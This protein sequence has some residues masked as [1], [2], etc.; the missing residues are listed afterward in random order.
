MLR[1]VSIQNFALI[2]HIEISFT[3]GFTVITGETGSGKSILLG[4]LGLVLGNRADTSVLLDKQRK[5]IVEVLFDISNNSQLQSWLEQLGLEPEADLYLR[6]EIAVTGKSRSFIND[7]PVNLSQLKDAAAMLVDLHQQFDTMELGEAYFQRNVI[8]ALAGCMQETS[9]YHKSFRHYSEQAAKLQLLQQQQ[10]QQ[11][12]E[13]DYRQFLLDELLAASFT[14]DELEKAE[15]ERTLLEHA[16]AVRSTLHEAT[17]LLKESETPVVQQL[18]VLLHKLQQY[19][20]ISSSLGEVCD[21]LGAVHIE[22]NDLASELEQQQDSIQADE[23]RKDYLTQRLELGY[24]LQKKHGV[25]STLQLLQ[26][27]ESLESEL[28]VLSNL[29]QEIAATEQLLRQQKQELSDKAALLYKKRLKEATPFAEKMNMLLKRVGM[30]NARMKVEVLPAPL[31]AYGAD[32]IRFLFNA[33]LPEHTTSTS[34]QME[35][36]GKVASGGELSRLM[37]CIQSLV[38]GKIELPSLI[39]DEIDTGISGEAARQVGLLL[40]ELSQ[41]HQVITITHLPQIAA[42]AFTHFYVYKEVQGAT[43]VTKV[44]QLKS[45]EQVEAIAHMLSGENITESTLLAAKE[46]VMNKQ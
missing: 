34:E 17:F 33:N 23:A 46:M 31:H 38:A 45:D 44:R 20:N 15:Q 8:D 39:F 16:E 2:D 29:E 35:P 19:R 9:S 37:L 24:K 12:R 14:A 13:Q 22:L 3:D 1:Q 32:T 5:C 36:I 25:Q 41:K 43:I 28:Q 30:P 18:K 27:Q 40:Q 26:L 10:Q 7:T 4:A 21:R 42:R 11:Q 6:R